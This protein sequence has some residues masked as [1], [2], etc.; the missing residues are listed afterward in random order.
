MLR[1]R[2]DETVLPKELRVN[3]KEAPT[4]GYTLLLPEVSTIALSKSQTRF[5]TA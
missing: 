2:A 5:N 1:Q 4:T 3:S